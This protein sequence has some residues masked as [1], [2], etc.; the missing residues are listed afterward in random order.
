MN[1]AE[2][3]DNQ[4]ENYCEYHWE[5]AAR[6]NDTPFDLVDF[7]NC[8][9]MQLIKDAYYE[10]APKK[11]LR[12]W[13]G[14]DKDDARMQD[15][16]NLAYAQ[17]YRKL[18]YEEI[19]KNTGISEKQLLPDDVE[20]IKGKLEGHKITEMQYFELK[21]MEKHPLFKNIVNKRIC[22]VKKVSVTDF[23]DYMKDYDK[24]VQGLLE[25]LDGDAESVVYSTIAL[26]TLEWKYNVEFFYTCAL[27][28]EKYGKNE[29]DPRKIG[30]LCSELQTPIFDDI[31]YPQMVW[32]HSR[33]ILNRMKVVPAIFD[34]SLWDPYEEKIY[35]Y[36]CIIHSFNQILVHHDSLVDYYA[37]ISTKEQWA[38]F[39]KNN[40]NLKELYKPKEWTKS[41]IRYVRDLYDYFIKVQPTPKS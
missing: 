29:I 24:L 6:A 18:Q 33:F 2:Y 32:I 30:A 36:L 23:Q 31:L 26:F 40:Y 16:R 14:N 37:N 9:I 5:N 12:S 25:G 39:F 13:R 8:F 21:T 28:A 3:I 17:H 10:K 15:S 22:D 7:R 34:G 35:H 20:D 19:L 1:I 4:I 41:R 38:D 11:S 27:N